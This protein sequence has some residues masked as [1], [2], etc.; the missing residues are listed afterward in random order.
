MFLFHL[1]FNELF[2]LTNI[3]FLRSPRNIEPWSTTGVCPPDRSRLLMIPQDFSTS[4][5]KSGIESRMIRES[6]KVLTQK[7]DGAPPP[8]APCAR[9]GAG[10]ILLGGEIKMIGIAPRARRI[11]VCTFEFPLMPGIERPQHPR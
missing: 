11:L 1:F 7:S 6:L 8:S 10:P 4:P 9:H 3:V 2:L 5:P